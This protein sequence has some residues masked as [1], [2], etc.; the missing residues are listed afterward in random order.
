MMNFFNWKCAYSG[1]SLNKN[2][3][4]IDHIIPLDKGGENEIWNCV[5]MLN[6]YNSSK[7]DKDII[8]WYENQEYFS[9]ERLNK[10]YEWVKYAYDNWGR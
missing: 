7:H 5:P 8:E 6:S 1:V 9:E 10:I 2:N 3:R 4:S